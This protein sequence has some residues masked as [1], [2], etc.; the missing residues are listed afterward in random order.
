VYCL[1][2]TTA[3]LRIENRETSPQ[4]IIIIIIG[5]QSPSF[6]LLAATE[7]PSTSQSSKAWRERSALSSCTMSLWVSQQSLDHERSISFFFFFY[8]YYYYTFSYGYI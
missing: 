3:D 1:F 4:S 5:V 2:I 7:A 8:F 6:P